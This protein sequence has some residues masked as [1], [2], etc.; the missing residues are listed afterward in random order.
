MSVRNLAIFLGISVVLNVLLVGFCAG[1]LAR[2]GRAGRGAATFEDRTMR[3]VWQRHDAMLRPRSEA[4][5]ASRRRVT[6]VLVA[7]PFQPEALETAL[8]QLRAETD[9][10][11]RALHRALVE[12]ARDLS[13]EDRRQMAASGW[14]VGPG[15]RRGGR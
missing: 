6:E 11:Q 9:V 14:L 1:Q 15:Q 2:G 8:T 5:E 7:E 12:S 4:L 13:P 10:A 3:G